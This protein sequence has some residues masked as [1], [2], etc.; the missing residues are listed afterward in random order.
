MPVSPQYRSQISAQGPLGPGPQDGVGDLLIEAGQAL[1]QDA[2]VRQ[3][4]AQEQAEQAALVSANDEIMGARSKWS[5]DLERRKL[6]APAGAPGFAKQTLTDFDADANDRVSRARTPKA[7]EYLRQRLDAVRLSLQDESQ[8][9]ETASGIADKTQKVETSTDQAATA[10][11]LKHTDYDSILAEQLVAIA[12]SGLP[13]GQRIAIAD[14]ARAKISRAA[15]LGMIRKDPIGTHREL[16]NPESELGAIRD[17]TAD[18]RSKFLA[19]AENEAKQQRVTGASNAITAAYERSQQAGLAAL[20]NLDKSGLSPE[21][22]FSV[23]AQVRQNMGLIHAERRQEFAEEVNELERAITAEAPGADAERRAAS[24]Y[25]RGVYTPEQYTNVLQ[26]IDGAR[27]QGA[28]NG[29]ASAAVAA[30]LESGS[31]LDPKNEKIVKAVDT[32]FATTTQLNK[33]QPGSDEY[34]NGAGVLAHKTNILP[35]SAMSWARASILSGDPKLVA[36][37]ATAMASWADAA[38]T[39]YAYFDDPNLKAYSAQVYSLI[40]AGASPSSAV[41]TVRANQQLPEARRKELATTYTKEKYAGDNGS[42]LQSRLNNDD[43]FDRSLSPTGAP[44][45]TEAMRSEYNASVRQYF[46]K[47]NG[48]IEQARELAWRDIRGMYGYST[49][50]GAPELLKHAPELRYPG[51]D[52]SVIRADIDAIAATMNVKTPV[53]MVPS[54]DTDL[55]QGQVWEL[56]TTDEDGYETTVLDERNRPVQYRIPTDTRVYLEKQEQAKKAAIDAARAESA[57]RRAIAEAIQNLDP[58][59][60]E[61]LP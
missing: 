54:L 25:S 20:Q 60:N 30:A 41:E 14:A 48:N 49:V 27:A 23:R 52:T 50:N 35:P 9:F 28:S 8:S 31:H 44:A 55:T 57:N 29:A 36:P 12:G 43:A 19:I 3:Q 38:P 4:F 15:V 51:I 7:R 45:A 32:L 33:V 34:I 5:E 47:T 6:E 26:A 59:K 18:A 58:L 24:L 10:A 1:G 21:D 2:L 42:E 37:A 56:H 13:E 17:L 11:E 40:A 53:R 46:E 22:Q 39:A 61:F 16:S